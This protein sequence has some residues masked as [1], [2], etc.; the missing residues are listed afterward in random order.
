MDST[1]SN[2]WLLVFVESLS[3]EQ[4]ENTPQMRSIKIDA[5]R[6]GTKTWL[7]PGT[8]LVVVL[9]LV[10]FGASLQVAAAQ[11]VDPASEIDQGILAF[12]EDRFQEAEQH[13]VKAIE[14][15]DQ[16]AEA[17]FLL[18][19]IY[20]ETPLKNRREAQRSLSRAMDLEPDN[21]QFMAA[22]LLQLREDSWSFVVD[23]L[24]E[25]RRRALANK[26]LKLDP[27]NAFANEELGISYI[28]D[29]WRYRNAIQIPSFEL[30]RRYVVSGAEPDGA[31]PEAF[32]PPPDNANPRDV[33]TFTESLPDVFDFDDPQQVFLADEFDL[34]A[35]E[36][37]GVPF[38]DLSRRASKV[39]DRAVNHL[40]IALE[41]NPRHRSVYDQL[42]K[43]YA[44]RGDYPAALRMLEQMYVY[45]PDDPGLWVYLGMANYRTGNPE[46]AAKTYERAM[47][48]FDDKTRSAYN[49]IRF[50]LV[51]DER[52]RYDENPA[53]FQRD[54]WTSKDPRYLTPYNERKIE[55]YNRV[56][57]ADLLYGAPALDIRGWETE[58]GQILIRYGVPKSDVVIVPDRNIDDTGIRMASTET[59]PLAAR[60]QS[61][62][63]NKGLEVLNTYNIWDYGEFRFVFEDPFRT[64]EFRLYSP[65]AE[66]I[67]QNALP[68]R[69]DYEISAKE[70]FRE[71]PDRFVYEA[72]GRQIELPYLVNAFKGADETRAEL[73]V[74]YG[75]PL[76]KMEGVADVIEVTAR[77]GT[78]LVASD[79]S[80]LSEE[81]RTIYG[82]NAEHI[83]NFADAS[84][85]I[86]THQLS[87]PAG[88]H[89][90]S[91]ELEIGSGSTVA[92]QR[93]SVDVPRFDTDNLQ[94][95][96]VMLAY[97]V[98]DAIG[99]KRLSGADI[100]RNGYSISPAPWSVFA[101]TQP[102]YLYFEF[103]NL[104]LSVDGKSSYEME[105]VLSKKDV[106]KGVSKIVRNVF[107]G[108]EKGVSV[109]VPG[110]GAS[111]DEGQYLIL[112]VANEEPGLYTLRVK[113]TDT[114]TR[115][116][117]ER[118][119][120]LFLE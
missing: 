89:E 35:L 96:D 28:R 88:T 62:N 2:K 17:H 110:A 92:V 48:A 90:L 75:I 26:I 23:K 119:K 19:R 87:A 55:H 29:F 1:L 77:E 63:N 38:R 56:A 18:A 112:D 106:S 3:A 22:N 27:N 105:A 40:T 12:R 61:A 93:R 8:V 98:E 95:S 65:S 46:A 16:N 39:Y 53:V 94:M 102:I 45:F 107:G 85:W 74:H 66:A 10:M 72:P 14:A 15:D 21:L 64:G 7:K 117:V 36:R 33:P 76:N 67:S 11:S 59:D 118:T 91:V 111:A 50:L 32:G 73:Y 83:R 9:A 41:T 101:T 113:V 43:V 60:D 30:A 51:D 116:S 44:L 79:R 108:R 31:G 20:F 68:W 114:V 120:D 13:F 52:G 70:T 99:G 109:R 37:Q 25:S 71:T 34:D 80:M 100:V 49:D 4:N 103:Y 84:L 81:R 54:Y 57:Y 5:L 104:S 47:E 24:R 82:L 86:N 115:K 97:G 58:R 69:N 42:M 78:F 6:P